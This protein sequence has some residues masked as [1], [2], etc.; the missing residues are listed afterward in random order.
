MA[1]S[2]D[3]RIT[4]AGH[5]AAPADIDRRLRQDIARLL[6]GAQPQGTDSKR[7]Q[8]G[9]YSL[10]QFAPFDPLTILTQLREAEYLVVGWFCRRSLRQCSDPQHG[11]IAK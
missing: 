6:L 11:K 4:H 9:Q 5:V 7:R 10:R 3:E 2:I 8:L 1:Q